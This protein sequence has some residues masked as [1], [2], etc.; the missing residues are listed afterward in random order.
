[1][2]MECK[3]YNVMDGEPHLGKIEECDLKANKYEV[4]DLIIDQLFDD[5]TYPSGM[6]FFFTDDYTDYDIEIDGS[7][8]IDVEMVVDYLDGLEDEG[9]IN[10]DELYARADVVNPLM[11]K[12]K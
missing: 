12:K 7:D 5:E 9:I 11:R 3:K 8:Y 6:I 4:E 2:Y 1:M 10:K